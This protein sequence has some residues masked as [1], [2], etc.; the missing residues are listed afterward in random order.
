[1]L[2]TAYF[3]QLLPGSIFYYNNR[4]YMKIEKVW[5][6]ETDSG[7]LLEKNVISIGNDVMQGKTFYFVWEMMVS[8]EDVQNLTN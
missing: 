5:K 3:H 7:D 6:V 8:V 1:M 2:K 4:K